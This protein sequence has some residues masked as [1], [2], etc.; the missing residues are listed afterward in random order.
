MGAVLCGIVLSDV[1]A[2]ILLFRPPDGPT[3]AGRASCRTV[4]LTSSVLQ[5]TSSRRNTLPGEILYCAVHYQVMYCTLSG[6]VLYGVPVPP[7]GRI[8]I[9]CV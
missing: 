4:S 8:K 1:S 2:V 3:A 7:G 6:D 9:I 5:S